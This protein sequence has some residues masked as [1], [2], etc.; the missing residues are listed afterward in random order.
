MRG[1]GIEIVIELLHVLAVIALF[2]TQPEQPFFQDGIAPVPER[3][4]EAEELVPIADAGDAVLVPAIGARAGVLEGEILPGGAFGAVVLAHGAPTALGQVRT[5]ALPVG[6]ALARLREPLFF[7]GDHCGGEYNPAHGPV[8]CTRAC[9]HS[10]RGLSRSRP[11]AVPA[12]LPRA[13][14]RGLQRAGHLWHH[15]RSE[16]ALAGR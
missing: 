5:P 6:R 10:F 9:P 2:S 16:L 4:G 14:R 12:P 15:Q 13:A 11:G 3:D 7:P 1:S 8:R